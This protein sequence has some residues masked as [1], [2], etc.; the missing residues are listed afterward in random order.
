ME[1]CIKQLL[2]EHLIKSG[3]ICKTR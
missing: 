1:R 2:V 3:I